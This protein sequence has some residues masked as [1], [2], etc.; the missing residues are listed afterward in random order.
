MQ[1][2]ASTYLPDICQFWDATT[3]FSPVKIHQI[4]IKIAK[5]GRNRPTFCV[6]C[7]KKGH[8][9]EESTAG[10]GDKYQLRPQAKMFH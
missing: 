1:M 3:L 10:G 4:R 6:L 2:V 9:L 8:Q 5:T 7:A